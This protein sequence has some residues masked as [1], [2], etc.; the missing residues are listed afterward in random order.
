M[1]SHRYAHIAFYRGRIWT[2]SPSRRKRY[3][4]SDDGIGLRVEALG[5][6]ADS[7]HE[8]LQIVYYRE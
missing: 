3:Y 5:D 7:K 8:V 6:D 1:E 4:Q 2:P